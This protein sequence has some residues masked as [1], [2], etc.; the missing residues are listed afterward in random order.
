MG[1]QVGALTPQEIAVSI[2]A[3]LIERRRGGPRR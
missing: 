1:V 2:V 3:R